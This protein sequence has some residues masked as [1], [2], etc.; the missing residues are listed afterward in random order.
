MYSVSWYPHKLTDG[1][2]SPARE[3]KD[4]FR[5]QGDNEGWLRTEL[6]LRGTAEVMLWR[7]IVPPVGNTC[8]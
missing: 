8:P 5:C 7:Q 2:D 6:M 3:V 1:R 4:V